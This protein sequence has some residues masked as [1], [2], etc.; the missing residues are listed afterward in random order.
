MACRPDRWFAMTMLDESRG[1][2]R[3]SRCEGRH[4]RSVRSRDLAIWGNHSSTQFPDAWHATIGGRPGARG[5]RRRGV[6]ARRVHRHRPAARRRDHQGARPSSSAASAANAVIDT[7]RNVAVPTGEQFSAA[8]AAPADRRLRACRRA[9]LR[10]SRC[11]RPRRDASRSCRAIEHDEFARA[12]SRGHDGRAARGARRG[13]G[14]AGMTA[15]SPARTVRRPSASANARSSLPIVHGAE[16]DDA[17]DIGRLR[18]PRP[19]SSRFD[20]GYGNTGACTSAI[21]FLDGEEGILRYRGYPI[22]Q[23]AEHSTLPRG[24]LPAHLGRAADARAARSVR[25]RGDASHPHPRG[26]AP[27]LRLVSRPMR[28]RWRCS[29]P[30]SSA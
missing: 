21:T 13:R 1:P 12:K 26:D 15:D 5:D 2:G 22:E 6:A 27:L 16:G 24:R 3:S 19:G 10:L 8:I 20:P 30:A 4:A 25:H 18:G 28:T 11:A 23:L 29:P 17:I 7:V 9:R 14:A